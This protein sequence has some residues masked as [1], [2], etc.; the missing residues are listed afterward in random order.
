MTEGTTT[1]A[2]DAPVRQLRR[3][4][5]ERIVAGVAGGLGRYFDLPPIF[6]RAAFVVLALLG[7]AGILLYVAAALVM[8]DEGRDESILEEAL[9]GHRDRPWLLI[10]IGL[11]AIATL[12]LVAQA[13]FWPN[14]GFAWTLLLVGVIAILW[15]QRR[16]ERRAPAIDG[17]P[18]APRRPSIA[19]P[20]LG[21]LLAGAGSL[22]LLDVL[23]VSIPWD[24]ALA[25]GA[26]AI[27]LAVAAGAVFQRRTGGLF[28]VGLLLAATA[29]FVSAV[30]IQL[31]G[32]VG[33]KVS[34]PVL[35]SDLE[36]TYHLA[37]G[38]LL[39]DLRNVELPSG[40]TRIDANVGFGELTVRVPADVDVRVEASAGL[41]DL[42]V[43]GRTTDGWD[44]ELS[45]TENAVG[46]TSELV[47]DA[48][49]GI[50]ELTVERAP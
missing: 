15:A 50:G 33:D 40:T 22:A 39:L 18:P 14:S 45:V 13:R 41:G 8:P 47:L 2:T 31:E 9:R 7:G 24:I 21:L 17:A 30:D 10:G 19:L 32:P 5:E 16:E 28:I 35:A 43:F 36:P 27:G 1:P 46:S 11:V 34:R 29:V 48:H 23:G 37:A 44:R 20:V 12:S 3:S 6:F 49:V 42:D 26:I 25:L 38:E 4:R